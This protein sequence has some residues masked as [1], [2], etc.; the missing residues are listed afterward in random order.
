MGGGNP[1]VVLSQKPKRSFCISFL[2]TLKC[3][4]EYIIGLDYN[5]NKR[6]SLPMGV[7]GG[8]VVLGEILGSSC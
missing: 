5:K 3:W 1:Q 2:L 7:G 6:H 8:G 4:Q